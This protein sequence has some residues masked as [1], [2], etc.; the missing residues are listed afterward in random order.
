LPSAVVD[1]LASI[2]S[3]KPA[4]RTVNASL[5]AADME[6][7]CDEPDVYDEINAWASVEVR[8]SFLDWV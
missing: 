5:V 7:L 6:L 1:L 8:L 3:K 2:F 4:D